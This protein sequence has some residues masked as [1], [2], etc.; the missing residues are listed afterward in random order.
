MTGDA[1]ELGLEWLLPKSIATSTG[2]RTPRGYG[3]A[4]RHQL[5]PLTLASN[6]ERTLHE[7]PGAWGYGGLEIPPSSYSW[8]PQAGALMGPSWGQDVWEEKQQWQ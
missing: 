4:D 7:Q 6:I 3:R 5:H 2:K 8:P 1:L